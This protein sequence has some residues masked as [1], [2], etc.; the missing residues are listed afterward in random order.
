MNRDVRIAVAIV[1]KVSFGV[2]ETSYSGVSSIG[3]S[4]PARSFGLEDATR[5]SSVPRPF[6]GD[7]YMVILIA[8]FTIY[9]V[10]GWWLGPQPVVDARPGADRARPL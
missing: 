2:M 6:G 7:L 4:V 5:R 1:G 9:M 8:V 3:R 10:V